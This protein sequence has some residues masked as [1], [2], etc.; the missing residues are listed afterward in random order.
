MHRVGLLG[1]YAALCTVL[2]LFIKLR[3]SSLDA[4]GP[5]KPRPGTPSKKVRV[6]S[7]SSL[8]L[9]VRECVLACSVPSF[10]LSLSPQ[11]TPA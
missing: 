6:A 11:S 3:V 1:M 4:A 10:L 9:G 5:A 8:L 7:C 2:A